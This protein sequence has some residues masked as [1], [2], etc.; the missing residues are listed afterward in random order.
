MD[1]E[2]LQNILDRAVR[3]HRCGYLCIEVE[4]PEGAIE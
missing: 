3:L 4:Q 2:L 1:W